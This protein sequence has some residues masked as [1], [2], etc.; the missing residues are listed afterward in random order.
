MRDFNYPKRLVALCTM[1]VFFIMAGLICLVLAVTYWYPNIFTGLGTGFITS[2]CVSFCFALVE[3]CKTTEVCVNFTVNMM[4]IAVFGNWYIGQVCLFS[5]TVNV[6]GN[7][8]THNM[9]FFLPSGAAHSDPVLNQCFLRCLLGLTEDTVSQ[10]MSGYTKCRRLMRGKYA[11]VCQPYVSCL[12]RMK[13]LLG[14]EQNAEKLW[15]G[16]KEATE[17]VLT[18]FGFSEEVLAVAQGTQMSAEQYM[19]LITKKVPELG[20]YLRAEDFVSFGVHEGSKAA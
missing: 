7:Q 13:A 18:H 15:S 17:N 6:H 10:M 11:A 1:T 5:Q 16:F 9:M 8:T 12:R 3:G 20:N 19:Q 4:A 14:E 2:A